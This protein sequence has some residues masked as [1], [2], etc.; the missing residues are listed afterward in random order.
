M[1]VKPTLLFE[2]NGCVRRYI[3]NR[4]KKLNA[5]DLSMIRGLGPKIKVLRPSWLFV[6][7]ILT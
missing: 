5:L 2:A 3:L 4:P 1:I 7:T 6:R